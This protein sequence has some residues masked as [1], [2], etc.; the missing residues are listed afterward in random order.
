MAG[1]ANGTCV[2]YKILDQVNYDHVD[3]LSSCFEKGW[4]EVGDGSSGMAP[5]SST[6]ST[7]QGPLLLHPGAPTENSVNTDWVSQ[8]KG[9]IQM[10]I[11]LL[12]LLKKT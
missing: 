4:K 5:G 6:I 12:L 7:D 3:W 1:L 2:S 8:A 11:L 10:L 9:A